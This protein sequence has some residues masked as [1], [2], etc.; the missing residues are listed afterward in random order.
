MYFKEQE[1]DINRNNYETYFLLYID[2]E[3]N[4]SEMS[5]VEKFVTENADLQKEFS[6]LRQTVL[7]PAQTVFDQK[8]L[9]F[10]KEEKRRV[11]PIYWTRIAAAVAVLVLGGW[12]LT[13][14]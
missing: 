13:S 11:I 8:E 4:P 10:R 5:E 3:L 7:L 12:L 6:L 1:M 14:Q 2:R 9:L